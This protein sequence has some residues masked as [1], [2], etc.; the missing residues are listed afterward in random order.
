MYD[1][2]EFTTGILPSEKPRYL[3]GVGTPLNIVESIARGVDMFDCVMPTRN[4][5]NA[6]LFTRQ[7]PVTIKKEHYLQDFRPVD[8]ACSCYT[9]RTFTRSYLC[10][11]YR[12]KEILGLQLASIHNLTFYLELT[13]DARNAILNDGFSEWKAAFIREYTA[14]GDD[15]DISTV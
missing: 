5:R 15:A 2:T 14:G 12:A 7:G 9:C 10:H 3:M 8:G 13:R 6:M 1:I 4:G 11:L